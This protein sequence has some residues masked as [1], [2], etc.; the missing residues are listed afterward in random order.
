[1]HITCKIPILYIATKY[2]ILAF[3][4]IPITFEQECH[5]TTHIIDMPF[6]PSHYS[7]LMKYPVKVIL[8]YNILIM[9]R[10]NHQI[11]LNTK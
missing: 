8:K 2:H 9:F 7:N 1:M 6:V 11:N 10:A 5:N 3:K 4:N